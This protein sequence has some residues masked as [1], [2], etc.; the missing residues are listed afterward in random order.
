MQEIE[1]FDLDSINTAHVVYIDAQIGTPEEFVINGIVYEVCPDRP[2]KVAGPHGYLYRCESG[3]GGRRF[4]ILTND[5][6]RIV[7]HNI[8]MGEETDAPDT[9]RFEGRVA[10]PVKVT[11]RWEGVHNANGNI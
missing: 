5:F 10:L 3:F 7:T 1:A 6:R 4:V 11:R 2:G 9:A 8:W